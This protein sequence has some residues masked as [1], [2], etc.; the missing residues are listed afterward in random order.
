MEP[1]VSDRI[2]DLSLEAR[3]LPLAERAEL[4][5]DLLASLDEPD[6]QIDALW[7][8]GA[9]ASPCRQRRNAGLRRRRNYRGASQKAARV[10]VRFA[11]DA[12]MDRPAASSEMTFCVE[13]NHAA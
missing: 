13:D 6:P 12:K 3:K 8:D 10:K 5:D 9:A 7:V 1:P 4:I 11:R 2:K